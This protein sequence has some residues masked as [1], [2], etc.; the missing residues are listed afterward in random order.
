MPAIHEL[1]HAHILP[2]ELQPVISVVA[3][4]DT[5]KIEELLKSRQH[6]TGVGLVHCRLPEYLVNID[7]Q[8]RVISDH[9]CSG[10]I[11]T[12]LEFARLAFRRVKRSIW[13]ESF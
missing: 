7:Y 11:F 8:S 12:K 1:L 3:D 4:G 10:L 2:V 9:F 5:T 6:F 13:P